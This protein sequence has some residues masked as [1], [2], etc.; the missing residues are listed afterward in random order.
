MFEACAS[1]LPGRLPTVAR[2]QA[3]RES[4]SAGQTSANDRQGQLAEGWW[5]IAPLAATNRCK[6]PSI[7]A[8]GSPH[9]K[10][11]TGARA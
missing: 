6:T 4:I 2:K 9:H 5:T 1:L 10:A 11:I 7:A 3:I 8:K